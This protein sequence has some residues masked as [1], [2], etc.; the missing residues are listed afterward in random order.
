MQSD[1]DMNDTIDHWKM[2][3]AT[4]KG[5]AFELADAVV[6]FNQKNVNIDHVM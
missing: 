3:R 6:W 1:N 2:Q 5:K 4:S